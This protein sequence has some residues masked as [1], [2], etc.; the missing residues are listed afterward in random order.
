MIEMMKKLMV[1]FFIL[2]GMRGMG[3]VPTWEWARQGVCNSNGNSDET[4]IAT[5]AY[6]NVYETGIFTGTLSFDNYSLTGVNSVYL[7]KYNSSGNVIWAKCSSGTGDGIAYG[8][9]TDFEGNIYITG[10]SQSP[11][12]I[13][14]SYTIINDSSPSFHIFIVKYDPNGNVLWGKGIDGIGVGNAITTDASGNIFLTGY[15]ISQILTC[16]THSINNLG[17]SNIFIAKFDPMGNPIWVKDFGGSGDD[18]GNSITHDN[19]GNFYLGGTFG[20]PI[21]YFGVDSIINL[22]VNDLLFARFDSSGNVI[23]LKSGIGVAASIDYCYGL[24]T[25]SQGN[26]YAAGGF[27]S[28]TN[29]FGSDTLIN[30]GGGWTVF[31]VKY[32]SSGNVLWAKSSVG[33][34]LAYSITSDSSGNTFLCG[35]LN[36]LDLIFDTV[37]IP[38]PS[39]YYDA[40]FMVKYNSSGNALF[41]FGFTSG[42]DDYSSVA[43]DPFGSLYL[44]G[45]FFNVNP[46]IIGNDSL[47]LSGLETPF[48]AKFGLPGD[49]IPKISPQPTIS[50]FPNPFS[51]TA[52]LSIRNY[53]SGM[54]NGEVRIINLLGQ[55]VKTIPI[56][57]QKEI[58]INRDN[59]AEG[60][61]F[62]KIIGNNN[63]SIAVGK[64]VIQ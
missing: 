9:A 45:D 11:S 7:V 27:N 12:I 51:T 50:L 63:E 20:S 44:G 28:P 61:Y 41:G 43:L 59:L 31:I 18:V 24:A 54:G 40:M 19:F 55:E 53:E 6:G 57:N 21:A 37:N 36:A 8:I 42:G 2:I 49:G 33:N 52:T 4:N 3:Q 64:I 16:G 1:V 32:D 30:Y 26:I 17:Y 34:G 14:G 15:F 25:D 62:Y 23:W 35:T 60:M 5:D 39:G 29:I 22:G 46:F 47:I 10:G 48:I 13:F 56:I 38:L 58:T